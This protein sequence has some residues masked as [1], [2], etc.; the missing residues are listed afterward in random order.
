MIRTFLRI[1]NIIGFALLLFIVVVMILQNDAS[2]VYF[3][4]ILLASLLQIPFQVL[5]IP[6]SEATSNSIN[7]YM[8]QGLIGSI[9]LFIVGL[10]GFIFFQFH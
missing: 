5:T 8:R 2:A 6:E 3:V 7:L 4:F 10:V 1:I 9:I